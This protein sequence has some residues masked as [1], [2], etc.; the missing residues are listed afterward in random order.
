MVFKIQSNVFVAIIDLHHE[1]M[2][3]EL[4]IF[5]VVAW[6]LGSAVEGYTNFKTS[7]NLFILKIILFIMF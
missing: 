1:I 6:L 4:Y 5:G 7:S 2:T 3:V